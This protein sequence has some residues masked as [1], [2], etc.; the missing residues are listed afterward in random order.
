MVG[1]TDLSK[2]FHPNGILVTQYERKDD[3]RFMFQLLKLKSI[4]QF[5]LE[6]T[7]MVSDSAPTITNGF[8]KILNY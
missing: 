3:F 6:P 1:T 7:V 4:Y 5:D 8:E 2:S